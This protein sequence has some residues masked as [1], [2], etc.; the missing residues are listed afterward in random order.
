MSERSVA[1]IYS[2]K[3]VVRDPAMEVSNERQEEACVR[4]AKAHG[5]AW[6]IYRDVD[7]SGRTEERPAWRQLKRQLWRG[8]VAAVIV[9]SLSRA[10]RSVR[11]FFN[12]LGE[13]EKYDVGLVSVKEKFDTTSAMGRAFLGVIA[14]LNQL[15]ADLASERMSMTIE[16]RQQEGRHWGLTPYGCQ[17]DHQ[18][19]LIPSEEG[20]WLSPTGGWVVGERGAPPFARDGATWHGYHDGLARLYELYAGGSHSYHSAMVEMNVGGWPFRTRWGLPRLWKVHDVR[21]V[22]QAWRLYAGDLPLGRQK[23]WSEEE[24]VVDGAHD[25]ILPP[26]LCQ[27]VGAILDDRN[28]AH[29]G[30]RGRRPHR[31][32]VL[33][34]I[35]YCHHCG[36]R[37]YGNFQKGLRSY[38]HH[39]KKGCPA[40]I[41]R[42]RCELVDDEV[43]KRVRA[44]RVLAQFDWE[45]PPD[46]PSKEDQAEKDAAVE[47]VRL[48]R[49]MEVLKELRLE[50]EIDKG[51]YYRRKEAILDQMSDLPAPVQTEG[52]SWAA[53]LARLEALGEL[54][55]E[56]NPA[57]QKRAL[58]AMFERIEVNLDTASVVKVTPHAWCQHFF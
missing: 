35:L 2:R 48:K 22:L 15:E 51:E 37:L 5:W 32:Y 21:R 52:V 50:G 29:G 38:S 8:D 7:V 34:D 36:E 11:D 23:D 26:A 44:L 46:F 3:S 20:A 47:R 54:I 25:P 39:R 9:E 1:L 33:S 10:N 40:V 57:A 16:Y 6:E 24:V 28:V 31:V 12:F 17:R 42:T 41:G 53:V 43:L 19:N 13:V 27:Q 58:N 45:R 49:K 55:A 4:E 56:A 30:K 14:I 18:H